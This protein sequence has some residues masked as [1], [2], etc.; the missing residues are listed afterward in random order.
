MNNTEYGF[1]FFF[2]LRLLI[3]W[4]FLLFVT[5]ISVAL[6]VIR[7]GPLNHCSP[8]NNYAQASGCSYLKNISF[9]ESRMQKPMINDCLNKIIQDHT[10]CQ[11]I[12]LSEK[13]ELRKAFP[14]IA[15]HSVVIL[16][17]N[18]D[19]GEHICQLNQLYICICYV[20]N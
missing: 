10:R 6:L 5:Q 20:A 12:N 2:L 19:S 16:L 17:Q 4:L 15:S 9:K 13:R 7:E 1:N 3:L 8:R 14:R 11:W 18:K